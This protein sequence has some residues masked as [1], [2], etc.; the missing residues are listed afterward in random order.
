[1]TEDRVPD[2]TEEI[3]GWRAWRFRAPTILKPARLASVTQRFADWQGGEWTYAEC[4]RGCSEIPGDDCSCGL[5]AATSRKHLAELGYDATPGV[6]VGE[7]GLAGKV[8]IGQMGYRAEKGRPR[9]LFV[10]Y[11]DWRL[12]R[13]LR[14]TF[15]VEVELVTIMEED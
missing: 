1:M 12:V 14:E 2:L 6:I 10:S 7:V 4:A 5:Y 8:V 11:F 13:P 9:R 15:G 3:I